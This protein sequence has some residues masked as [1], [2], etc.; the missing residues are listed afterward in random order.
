MSNTGIGIQY[1]NRG[2]YIIKIS[3][4]HEFLRIRGMYDSHN[5]SSLMPRPAPCSLP[6]SSLMP[7]L[8]EVYVSFSLCQSRGQSRRT[9]LLVFFL[10]LPVSRFK[11]DAGVNT[12]LGAFNSVT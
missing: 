2:L 6:S 10:L 9:V 11:A 12:I 1:S 7:A 3:C 8:L 5:T 4:L